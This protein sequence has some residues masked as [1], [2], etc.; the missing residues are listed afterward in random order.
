MEIILKVST[1]IC[2]SPPRLQKKYNPQYQKS[3][4]AV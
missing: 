4:D 2:K 3:W 1:N